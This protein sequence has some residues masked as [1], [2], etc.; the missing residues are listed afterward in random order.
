LFLI[1]HTDEIH[2]IHIAAIFR[3]PTTI[4]RIST[5]LNCYSSHNYKQH[6]PTSNNC[7]SNITNHSILL[8][9]NLLLKIYDLKYRTKMKLLKKHIYYH[10]IYICYI[11]I[12]W[13]LYLSIFDLSTDAA[14]YPT[15]TE[16]YKSFHFYVPYNL[17]GK[18]RR[19]DEYVS[20]INSLTD[21][22]LFV[23]LFVFLALQPIVVVFS[24]AR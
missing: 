3:W 22:S 20:L 5:K 1:Y 19:R 8:P 12:F 16:L 2:A 14:S 15:K 7:G 21:W 23:C 9:K 17:V 13:K 24:T 10:I 6:S 11:L 18:D 4:P